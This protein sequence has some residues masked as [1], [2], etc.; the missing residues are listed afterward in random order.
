MM[1]VPVIAAIIVYLYAGQFLSKERTAQALAELSG[2][3]RRGRGGRVRRDG[4]PRSW[5]AALG[6]LRPHRQVH[7]AH[8]AP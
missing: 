4:V 2:R 6:A 3:H 7:P 1:L 8:G 5:A